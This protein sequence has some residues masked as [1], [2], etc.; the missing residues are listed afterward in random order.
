MHRSRQFHFFILFNICLVFCNLFRYSLV[1]EAQRKN[2]QLS[3]Q[4][5]TLVAQ[6]QELSKMLCALRSLQEIAKFAQQKSM[7]PIRLNQIRTV[8]V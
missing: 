4:Y 7:H 3:A 2:Q 6:Q 1:L 5:K 8:P